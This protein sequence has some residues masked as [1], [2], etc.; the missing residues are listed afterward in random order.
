MF[1]AFL[2]IEHKT[3]RLLLDYILH[4]KKWIPL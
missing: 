2:Q 3:Q 1:K 4:S